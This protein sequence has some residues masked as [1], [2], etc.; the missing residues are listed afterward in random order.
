MI[1]TFGDTTD[2]DLVA[3]APAACTHRSSVGTV[4]CYAGAARVR[5]WPTSVP[6]PRTTSL[7]ARPSSR[8]RRASSSCSRDAGDLLGGPEADHPPGEVLRARRP[9]ARDRVHAAVVLPQ[10]RPRRG[11]CATRSSRAAR[12]LRWHPPHMRSRYENWVEGLNGDWLISRQRYFGVPFPVWYRARRTT[13]DP[14]YDQPIVADETALPVDPSSRRRP[15]TSRTSAARPDGFVGDP[16]V[17][18]TWATSSL[19]PEIACWLG[20]RPRPLRAHVP[21]GPAPAGARDH[22]HLAVRPRSCDRSF[23]F[24]GLP[25]TDAAISGWVLDPDRKKMSKSKGNVVT[26][27]ELLDQYG[28]DAM[29]YWAAQRAAGR[30][31]RGRRGPDEGRAAGSRSRSSTRRSSRSASSATTLPVPTR[32]P[33]RSTGRCSRAS[34]DVVDDATP[35]V[36][37]LTTTRARSTH[38]AVLLGVLRRLP[39]AGEATRLRLA[40]RR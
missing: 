15:G 28:A 34:R 20:G 38:R 31:H 37:R 5:H 24:D 8:R 40:R 12:E 14:D 10:R 7:R 36:R 17:M 39:R 27:M 1:C 26:P 3:R 29:R 25:W 16:D 22:P 35:R 19:T 4:A 13:A 30:R 9:T 6:S 32:S 18:D 2:V 11:D 21:D 33:R 23:E